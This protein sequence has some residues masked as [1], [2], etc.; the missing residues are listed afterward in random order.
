M[1]E[2]SSIVFKPMLAAVALHDTR[3][4]TIAKWCFFI[5]RNDKTLTRPKWSGAQSPLVA[6]DAADMGL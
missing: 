6:W 2:N 5:A 1:S 4:Y 3:T